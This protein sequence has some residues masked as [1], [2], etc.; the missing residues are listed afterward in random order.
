[1]N[2]DRSTPS[3]A[4]ADPPGIAPA[5]GPA[6]TVTAPPAASEVSSSVDHMPGG[7]HDLGGLL[8]SADPDPAPS[9]APRRRRRAVLAWTL[10]I[11]GVLLLAG[12]GAAL[13]LTANLGY[14]AARTHLT[15]ALAKH[16]DEAS[17]N[18]RVRAVDDESSRAA[19][20]LLDVA[21]PALLGDA[22]R[23]ELTASRD[24][25]QKAS[26][27][28]RSLTSAKTPEPGAKPSWFWDLYDRTARIEADSRAMRTLTSDLTRSSDELGSAAGAVD[29]TGLAVI[30]KGGGLAAQIENDNR[31]SP[32][33]GVL[34]LRDLGARL[35][36]ATSFDEDVAHGFREYAAT[37]QKVRD[38]HTATLA[39]EAG[40]LQDARQ[41]IEDFARSLVPGV[42]L[43]FEW[44][45]RVNDL[46]GDNG[47]LSGETLTPI[48]S[49]EYA[50]I[51]LSN[52][53]AEDWPG[54]SS[55]ALVAHEAGHAIATKC[56]TMVDNTDSPAAEAW[57]TAWAIS[58]GFTDDGN[59]TQ[60]YGSPPDSLVEK[61][62]G[63]R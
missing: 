19:D 45:D 61:A 58:M 20:V 54:D 47:Y 5:V 10:P 9:P 29:R 60:A 22:D 32:N 51:R 26:A 48:Q 36:A 39:A 56:R 8:V 49:G 50:T 7:G 11:A 14:D 2:D 38:G 62:A 3:E 16:D 43:D 15:T 37:A 23:A 13:Q 4:P 17:H 40:P 42:L 46:G 52:S 25:A 59:G 57:A 6:D 44:A 55:K 63:C 27:E 12:I 33:E 1:M 41:Q 18:E 28:A 24:R 31:P 35:S 53:I 34:A 21:D 30:K